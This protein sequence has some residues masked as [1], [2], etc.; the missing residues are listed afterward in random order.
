MKKTLNTIGLLS[1][2]GSSLIADIDIEFDPII[3]EVAPGKRIL[4]TAT[5]EDK[6][7]LNV[8]RT[9]FKAT[10]AVNY[11]FVPMGCEE[12]VCTSILPALSQETK[13]MD[14][15]VLVKNGENKVYKTQT[16]NATTLAVSKEIPEYQN[17]VTEGT[18]Q[19]KTELPKAPKMVEGFSDNITIDTVDSTLRFGAVAGVTSGGSAAAA[20]SATGTTSAGTIAAGAAGISTTVAVAGAVAVAG[21]AAVVGNSGSGGGNTTIYTIKNMAGTWNLTGYEVLSNG[22]NGCQN[23]TGVA[24]L[25]SDG[26]ATCNRSNCYGES[27]C[28]GTWNISSNIVTIIQPNWQ[29]ECKIEN[30]NRMSCSALDDDGD[31][32]YYIYTRD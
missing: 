1:I 32:W 25:Y 11:S 31:T 29:R 26:T 19:V 22:A 18:I 2:I 12:T 28:N 16:F 8:V 21:G 13:G 6:A 23:H 24:N 10:D 5:I 9:Y 30:L 14:Y 3:A 7:G 17:V 4:V 27:T 20:A 15:L